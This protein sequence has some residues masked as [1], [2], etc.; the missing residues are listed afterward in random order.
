MEAEKIKIDIIKQKIVCAYVYNKILKLSG[1]KHIILKN[2]P[3]RLKKKSA[4][5]NK[6]RINYDKI[7]EKCKS[8]LN[9]NL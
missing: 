8:G 5:Y 4:R 6:I 9:N 7:I 2:L 1:R 3:N